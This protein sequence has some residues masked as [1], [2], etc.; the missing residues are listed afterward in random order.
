MCVC[1]ITFQKVVSKCSICLAYF[2]ECT[3]Y[4]SNCVSQAPLQ[5]PNCA[6]LVFISQFT[7]T[8]THAYIQASS[9][10]HIHIHIRRAAL[11]L[12]NI[13]QNKFS[14]FLFSYAALLSPP[15][16]CRHFAYWACVVQ[17]ILLRFSVLNLETVSAL[18][19]IAKLFSFTVFSWLFLLLL[20]QS[21]SVCVCVCVRLLC[22]VLL[23][24]LSLC[25]L[26]SLWHT[27]THTCTAIRKVFN[28]AFRLPVAQLTLEL[29][30]AELDASSLPPSPP[31]THSSSLAL[32][33]SLTNSPSLCSRKC[34]AIAANKE[35]QVYF[36]FLFI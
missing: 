11:L 1:L 25:C 2:D 5:P 6:V 17:S 31:H 4:P 29:S 26:A 27:H 10:T 3:Y 32:A 16:L 12:R 33:R 21:A 23:L 28:G 15:C 13:Q 8:H 9:F 22:A 24:L 18:P 7:N 35:K 36:F 20:P 14:S 34:D 19:E 30:S